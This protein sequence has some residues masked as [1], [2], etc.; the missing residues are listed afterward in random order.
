MLNSA[1][2]FSICWLCFKTVSPFYKIRILSCTESFA[3]SESL[4]I[5][6]FG[7]WGSWWQG[8]PQHRDFH[9]VQ[10]AG[11]KEESVG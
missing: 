10:R 3:L 8:W 1:V 11:E 4:K 6:K 9:T 7:E 5:S 2:L